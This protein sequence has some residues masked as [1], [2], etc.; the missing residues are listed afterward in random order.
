MV[1]VLLYIEMVNNF[2]VFLIYINFVG[3]KIVLNVLGIFM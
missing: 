3:V 1:G 2:L